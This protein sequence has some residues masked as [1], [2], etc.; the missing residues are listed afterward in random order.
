MKRKC[1]RKFFFVQ[2]FSPERV[3]GTCRQFAWLHASR[4][5]RHRA[6]W[7]GD[8]D[9]CV[10]RRKIP[11]ASPHWAVA[12]LA[13]RSSRPRPLDQRCTK[14]TRRK[15]VDQ[16][17]NQSITTINQSIAQSINQSQQS[18][19]QNNP[20]ITEQSINQSIARSMNQSNLLLRTKV[21]KNEIFLWLYTPVVRCLQI[22]LATKFE[23]RTKRNFWTKK[24]NDSIQKMPTFL[25]TLKNITNAVIKNDRDKNFNNRKKNRNFHHFWD[26][27]KNTRRKL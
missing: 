15:L 24:F 2:D 22:I 25:S 21:E 12:W 20:S 5:S 19:N 23:T 13:H 27:E 8:S 17:I 26:F 18:I 14:T 10:L 7:P 16:S 4:W 6:R 3:C 1:D 11:L 9:W